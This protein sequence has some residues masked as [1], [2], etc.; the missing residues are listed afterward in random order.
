MLVKYGW[1]GRLQN[2]NVHIYACALV[3]ALCLCVAP[4]TSM[5]GDRRNGDHGNNTTTRGKLGYRMGR[6][7]LFE[8]CAAAAARAS[9]QQDARPFAEVEVG[10]YV[11]GPGSLGASVDRACSMVETSSERAG[12]V[13]HLHREV[14]TL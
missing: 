7:D 9:S 1:E 12:C 14:F 13:F 8:A 5:A 11:C 6:P 2:N 4:R 3:V 10:V